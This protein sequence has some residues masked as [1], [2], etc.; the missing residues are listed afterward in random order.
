MVQGQL[1]GS[2][3]YIDLLAR[4]LK[5]FIFT[6]ENANADIFRFDEKVR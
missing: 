1:L 5:S 4:W 2:S 6:C 3:T